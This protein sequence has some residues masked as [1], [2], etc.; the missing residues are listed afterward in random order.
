M[1]RPRCSVD[2][3]SASAPTRRDASAAISSRDE[4][5]SSCSSQTVVNAPT[6]ICVSTV[7][8]TSGQCGCSGLTCVMSRGFAFGGRLSGS[9]IRVA[10]RLE[11]P[12]GRPLDSA[13]VATAVRHSSTFTISMAIAPSGQALTQAGACPSD[14]R[15]WHMSHLPTTPRSA[16]YCGTPYEQFQVQYWQPIHAS[17][18]CLPMP[19]AGS[20]V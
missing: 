5:P 10:D 2:A 12:T 16:L 14:K 20:L 15:P 18:L 9:V 1:G 8:T 17:A 6:D 13:A 7:I 3:L 19:V 4:A 11:S